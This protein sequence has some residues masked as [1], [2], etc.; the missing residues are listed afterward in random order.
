MARLVVFT[1]PANPRDRQSAEGKSQRQSFVND[2]LLNGSGRHRDSSRLHAC[3]TREYKRGSV[4]PSV[5]HVQQVF[6]VGTAELCG[7][8]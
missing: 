4:I 3:N 1:A 8:R 2:M 7:S 6:N 5:Q